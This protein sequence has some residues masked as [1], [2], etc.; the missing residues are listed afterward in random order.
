MQ[1]TSLVNVTLINYRQDKWS[2]FYSSLSF[3]I[4]AKCG[5]G[6]MNTREYGIKREWR[7]GR[8]KIGEGG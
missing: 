2:A 4:I 7:R 8:K 5:K 6:L 1:E 3:D